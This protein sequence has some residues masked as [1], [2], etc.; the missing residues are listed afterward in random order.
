[1]R[2]WVWRGALAIMVVLVLLGGVIGM[3]AFTLACDGSLEGSRYLRS[4][5]RQ[6]AAT[7]PPPAPRPTAIPKPIP[8]L[9]SV[10]DRARETAGIVGDAAIGGILRVKQADPVAYP[11]HIAAGYALD[12]AGCGEDA[13]RIQWLKAGLHAS[14]DGQPEYIA[15]VLAARATDV[16]D[17]AQLRDIVRKWSVRAPRSRSLRRVRD[18]IDALDT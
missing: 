9:P 8:A 1:M 6:V 16:N 11:A 17:W 18:A 15:R 3:K 13:V 4:V 12:V 5:R 7:A 14:R 2:C 10:V